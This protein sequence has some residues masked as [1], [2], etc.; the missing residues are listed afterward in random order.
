MLDGLSD[1]GDMVGDGLEDTWQWTVEA[2]NDIADGLGDAWDWVSEDG[3]WAA[4]GET[5][6]TGALLAI[7]GNFE[8]SAAILGNHDLYSEEG[9]YNLERER[10]E[11]IRRRKNLERERQEAIERERQRILEE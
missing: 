2:G 3:N 6:G 5:L 11:E 8:D 9:R 7:T 1:F 4:L 10:L